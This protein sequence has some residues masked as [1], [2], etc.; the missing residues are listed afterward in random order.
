MSHFA[1][2]SHRL[3]ERRL[4]G[5][6]ERMASIIPG[7]LAPLTLSL[8]VFAVILPERP[9]HDVLLFL[10]VASFVWS[11]AKSFLESYDLDAAALDRAIL[12]PL[13]IANR[14]LAAARTL[15]VAVVLAFSTFNIA[16][17]VSI[18][19]AFRYGLPSALMV[20]LAAF[21]AA[22]SGLC[23][24]QWIR[25]VLER[26]FGLGRV[27][28][29]EGP[30]RLVVGV[31]L[32]T[33]LFLSP[34][35]TGWL[36]SRPWLH[37]VPPISFAF[38]LEPV[39]GPLIGSS[40]GVLVSVGLAWWA[41]RLAG[42]GDESSSAGAKATAPSPVARLARRFF[43]RPEERFAFDFALANQSRDR[44]FRS[45]VY[46]SFAFPFAVIVLVAERPEEPTLVLMALYG[47]TVYLALA[48]IFQGF[49]ESS[50]GPALLETL[51][52]RNQA[53]FRLGAEK[54]FM[55]G[56]VV[57]V[58]LVLAF[59]L[60]GLSLLGRGFGLAQSVGHTVL[61]T[62]FA[63]LVCS[64][65]FLSVREQAFSVTDQGVYAGN[66][67]SG[68]FV[69]ILLGAL[70]AVVAGVVVES[71]LLFFASAAILALLIR[72]LYAVKRRSLAASAPPSR[73]GTA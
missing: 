41:F 58:Y 27:Q 42:T 54:A 51:P 26:S 47:A 59:C 8:L 39:P 17:P 33:L 60:L 57:P 14:T 53:A 2:L 71:P 29:F 1:L 23:L 69:A 7:M 38:L 70:A 3:L 4:L 21:L 40:A 25:A 36:A 15:V 72:G 19:V 61:A 24:A 16:L 9:L 31:A 56:L 64:L 62:E 18:L 66:L 50:G 45:R 43:V 44:T 73:G 49:S 32:F 28:D 48:E 10:S 13:P 12:S 55:A 65:T 67:S 68:P 5:D 6:G 63:V 34:D 22:L 20:L 30:L 37:A 35:P 46:P 11:A 52:I